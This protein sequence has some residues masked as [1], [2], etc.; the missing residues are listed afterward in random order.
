MH[1]FYGAFVF[2]NKSQTDLEKHEDEKIIIIFHFGWTIHKH[3]AWTMI[4]LTNTEIWQHFQ[5]DALQKH[6]FFPQVFYDWFTRFA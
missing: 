1:H 3:C 2:W 5:N 6:F 4:S